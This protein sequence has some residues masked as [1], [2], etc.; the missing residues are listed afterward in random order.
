[1]TKLQNQINGEE[2]VKL[3]KKDE[4]TLSI[5]ISS[6]TIADINQKLNVKLKNSIKFAKE[7]IEAQGKESIEFLNQL[8][9]V[10]ISEELKKIPQS[11]TLIILVTSKSIN[12]FNS[13][14]IIKSTPIINFGKKSL[15]RYFIRDLNIDREYYLLDLSQKDTDLYLMGRYKIENI[16]NKLGLPSG[17]QDLFS[18][19]KNSPRQQR[20]L[21]KGSSV[22]YG[23]SGGKDEHSDILNSY[24]HEID[25]LLNDKLVDKTKP[26]MLAGTEDII[27]KFLSLSKYPNILKTH[28]T[29]SIDKI[30]ESKIL[31]IANKAL[32]IQ[33]EVELEEIVKN[34]NNKSN[35]GKVVSDFVTIFEAAINGRVE[36]LVYKRGLSIWGQTSKGDMT[37]KKQ[38]G[39]N[40]IDLVNLLISTVLENSGKVYVDYG[41]VLKGDVLAELRY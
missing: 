6:R 13:I 2:V 39:I 38:R 20:S 9:K 18:V 4:D 41:K 31:E 34:I 25:N 32:D 14:R 23:H 10:D 28:I 22:F 36:T 29:R 12:V 3:C 40:D 11:H 24:F 27:N 33:V 5:V 26:M 37:L 19:E 21:G 16:N 7:Q 15:V 30:F 35:T 17:F 8:A 1:M